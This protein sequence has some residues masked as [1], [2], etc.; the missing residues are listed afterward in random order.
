[1]PVFEFHCPSCER[2]F[3]EYVRV[4]KDAQAVACPICG[5]RR[6]QRKLSVFAARAAQPSAAPPGA[7]GRC[8]DPNGPCA[9]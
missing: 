5:A 6:V 9:M 4:I 8:G 3:E 2:D 1:M 7:C